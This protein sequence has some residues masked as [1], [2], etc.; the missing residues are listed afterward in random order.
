MY[1]IFDK[2]RKFY[3]MDIIFTKKVRKKDRYSEAKARKQKEKE[4]VK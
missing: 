4:W 1:R 2:N 3:M